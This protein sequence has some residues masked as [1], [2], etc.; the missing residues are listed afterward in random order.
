MIVKQGTFVVELADPQLK[1]AVW[2]SVTDESVTDIPDKDVP[3]I[4]KI[5]SKMFKKYPPPTKKQ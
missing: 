3:L 2:W 4:Q 1:K 5:I